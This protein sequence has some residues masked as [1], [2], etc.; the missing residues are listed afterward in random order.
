MI[1]RAKRT[2]LELMKWAALSILLGLPVAAGA[3]DAAVVARLND[4]SDRY[5]ECVYF[6]AV[7]QVN[8]SQLDINLA[9]EQAFNACKSETELMLQAMR[10]AGLSEP[11]IAKVFLDKKTG[12]K[13]ELRKMMNEAQGIRR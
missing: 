10:E 1:G 6:S 9:A 8:P 11:Q 2:V 12:I 13:R 3:Q 5:N 4:V 7:S